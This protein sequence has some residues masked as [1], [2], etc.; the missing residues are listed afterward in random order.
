MCRSELL[1][2][3]GYP[4]EIVNTNGSEPT[5]A[6]RTCAVCDGVIAPDR[7]INSPTCSSECATEWR[8][9]QRRRRHS[10]SRE[11]PTDVMELLSRCGLELLSAEVVLGEERWTLTRQMSGLDQRV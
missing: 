10:E 4:E 7:P 3:R 9:A 11:P 1:A 5:V 2:G 8:L 6:E